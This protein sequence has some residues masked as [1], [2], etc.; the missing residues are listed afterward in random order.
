MNKSNDT[1]RILVWD[2]ATRIFHWS[3]VTCFT[4]AFLTAEGDYRVFHVMF[5]Y[6]M[7][8]LLSF[9]LLWGFAGSKYVR[10]REFIRGPATLIRYLRSLASKHPEHYVGHNPAGAL[11]ILMLL[12]FG[13]STCITGPMAYDDDYS[14]DVAMVHEWLA[15]GML[16]VVA[17]HVMGAFASSYLHRENLILAMIIGHKDGKP[18]QGIHSSRPLA[19]MLLAAAMLGFWFFFIPASPF[20][21]GDTNLSS[22]SEEKSQQSQMD[23]GTNSNLSDLGSKKSGV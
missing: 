1:Q 20:G 13:F 3:L 5:G 9:R 23:T 22:Q 12:V 10:F 2:L 19:G 16:S 17:M 7:L 4:G 14:F 18:G 8:G 15:Y 11:A 6:T 21:V